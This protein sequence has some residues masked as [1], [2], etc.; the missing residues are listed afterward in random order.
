MC[1]KL[2]IQLSHLCFFFFFPDHDLNS[3]WIAFL[4]LVFTTL[5]FPIPK[6]LGSP[7]LAY[8]VI[9]YQ[10]SVFCVIYLPSNLCIA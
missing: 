2:T 9:P 4:V 10:L 5:H 8:E 7:Q 3:L 1:I 6:H